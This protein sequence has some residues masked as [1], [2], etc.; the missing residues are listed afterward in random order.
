MSAEMY[1]HDY[2][3]LKQAFKD[4]MLKYIKVSMSSDDPIYEEPLTLDNTN[5]D[6]CYRLRVSEILD[7]MNKEDWNDDDRYCR[8]VMEPTWAPRGISITTEC[9]SD[10]E[11]DSDEE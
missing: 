10:N 1:K 4:L 3:C 2:E 6:T 11:D 7:E 8:L 9:V 5:E